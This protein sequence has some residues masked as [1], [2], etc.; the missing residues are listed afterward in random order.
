MFHTN[1]VLLVCYNT[2]ISRIKQLMIQV[3]NLYSCLSTFVL[4]MFSGSVMIWTSAL[5][6]TWP[7]TLKGIGLVLYQVKG[8]FKTRA[9]FQIMSAGYFQQKHL[10]IVVKV[11]AS[12][13][14]QF[15]TNAKLST[16]CSTM[17]DYFL[18]IL[19]IK[20]LN[21]SNHMTIC[22]QSWPVLCLLLLPLPLKQQVERNQVTSAFLART[23][24][25]NQN[26]TLQLRQSS[27]SG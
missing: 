6:F 13:G 25:S 16:F 24:W 10:K 27:G 14:V 19:I 4:K 17:Q 22:M 1:N 9:K 7:K 5:F 23:R 21:F 3:R 26:I 18:Y 12:N 2:N 20:L 8:A 11:K 15:K